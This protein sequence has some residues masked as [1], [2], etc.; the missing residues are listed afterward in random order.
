MTMKRTTVTLEVHIEG[1]LLCASMLTASGARF[2][3]GKIVPSPDPEHAIAFTR[4]MGSL[5][6][7]LIREATGAQAVIVAEHPSIVHKA[8]NA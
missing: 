2:V 4:L 1:G 5:A 6:C 8:G 7:A 3:I